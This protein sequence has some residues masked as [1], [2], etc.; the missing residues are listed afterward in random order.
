MKQRSEASFHE[1]R[2][3]VTAVVISIFLFV[4]ILL[5]DRYGTYLKFSSVPQKT[6][7]VQVPEQFDD[8]CIHPGTVIEID[9]PAK[10]YTRNTNVI[11]PAFVYLPYGYDDSGNTKY[12]VLY[13]MHGWMMTAGDFYSDEFHIKTLFDHLIDNGNCRPFIAVS[14]TF[15][16]ENRPQSYERSVEEL[17]I[18]HY[19]FAHDVLPYIENQ[20]PT[21]AE[22]TSVKGLKRSREHRAFAGFSMGAVTTWHQFIFNLNYVHSFLSMSGD[23]WIKGNNGGLLHTDATV[24]ELI[25]AIRR[26]GWHAGDFL[27]YAGVGTIDPMYR[28]VDTQITEMMRRQEFTAENLF[29][30]VKENGYHDMTAAREYFYNALP[31]IFPA[32]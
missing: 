25:K 8:P 30:G 13:L 17:A 32:E 1:N 9:Y 20:F 7:T 3:A 11:K 5:W 24:N 19:E 10:D 22:D 28:Q 27:I 26:D 31:L 15:D 18:F 2:R 21:Y 16:A 4:P 6:E 14:L 29:Y 23:C 12:D